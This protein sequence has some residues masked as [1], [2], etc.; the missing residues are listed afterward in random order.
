MEDALRSQQQKKSA[1]RSALP[2]RTVEAPSPALPE[3]SASPSVG[4]RDKPPQKHK[5]PPGEVTLDITNNTSAIAAST[6][7]ASTPPSSMLYEAMGDAS[8]FPWDAVGSSPSRREKLRNRSAHNSPQKGISSASNKRGQRSASSSPGGVGGMG[9]NDSSSL[10]ITPP[11]AAHLTPR[12]RFNQLGQ[13]IIPSLSTTNTTITTADASPESS[14]AAR[15]TTTATTTTAAA[16]AIAIAPSPAA[17]FS[18]P[19]PP[20]PPSHSGSPL[21]RDAVLR[22]Q[23]QLFQQQQQ[24]QCEVAL[25]TGEPRSR[26]SPRTNMMLTPVKEK[27]DDDGTSQRGSAVQQLRTPSFPRHP[28]ASSPEDDGDG[29]AAASSPVCTASTSHGHRSSTQPAMERLTRTHS[30]HHFT[31][32][33]K[34]VAAA[35]LCVGEH[36][37]T[38]KA[39]PRTAGSCGASIA[40]SLD[41]AASNAPQLRKTAAYPSLAAHIQERPHDVSPNAIPNYSAAAPPPRSA[42]DT[43]VK[44]TAA[45][46]RTTSREHSMSPTAFMRPSFSPAS[47]STRSSS[48]SSALRDQQH[49]ELRHM[50]QQPQWHAGASQPVTRI[51]GGG[52]L[53][54]PRSLAV[55]AAAAALAKSKAEMAAAAALGSGSVGGVLGGGRRAEQDSPPPRKPSPAKDAA[56]PARAKAFLTSVSATADLHPLLLQREGSD[57]ASSAQHHQ[58]QQQQQRPASTTDSGAALSSSV[59]REVE[60]PNPSAS[61][62]S[63]P[64]K[65]R[66]TKQGQEEEQR[67]YIPSLAM[68]HR[69]PHTAA[70]QQNLRAH[71]DDAELVRLY[72]L[73]HQHQHSSSSVNASAPSATK[74][75]RASDE[76]KT[77]KKKKDSVKEEKKSKKAAAEFTR[78]PRSD[79]A[80]DEGYDPPQHTP[81]QKPSSTVSSQ[82]EEKKATAAEP[83]L[84]RRF[85]SR[86]IDADEVAALSPPSPVSNTCE[87]SVK[88]AH[89]SS[90]HAAHEEEKG[91]RR[92]VAQ[93]VSL[94]PSSVSS[95]F[96]NSPSSTRNASP[97]PLDAA[98]MSISPHSALTS[99]SVQRHAPQDHAARRSPR[100]QRAVLVRRVVRRRRSEV[101]VEEGGS[102]V[103]RAPVAV[104][105]P[106]NPR[107]SSDTPSRARSAT[108]KVRE[109]EQQ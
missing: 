108:R 67:Q 75:E 84:P 95:V 21:P 72:E 8:P 87:E 56:V 105:L 71:D 16:A 9:M 42:P 37:P 109:R 69:T 93:S 49:L 26:A 30:P 4:R 97:A 43:D 39:A 6:A 92:V 20:A 32:A 40:S 55:S 79:R 34:A 54:S 13:L 80:G 59:N 18:T 64:S 86:G 101:F 91:Q 41:S 47:S 7:L 74:A 57:T 33:S 63:H 89:A 94:Y 25:H 28:N 1:P 38:S 45:L 100:P 99:P 12:Q 78:T 17:S 3:T 53:Q 24:Q 82:V 11:L 73:L 81:K 102:L 27:E 65:G 5:D 51:R 88:S 23:K 68:P 62:T 107:S 35:D 77:R 22:S 50:Q 106:S 15:T 31:T 48:N 104:H 85:V 83:H 19:P 66:E 103:Y 29:A 61:C 2:S 14:T 98:F 70:L 44:E 90:C 46:Q 10:Q 76:E 36:K 52:A 96:N 60:L 58:Q